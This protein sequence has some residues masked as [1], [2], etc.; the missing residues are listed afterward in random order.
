MPNNEFENDKK[1]NNSDLDK[2]IAQHGN[3]IE[4]KLWRG[5]K[6]S[7]YSSLKV[8]SICTG[9]K[10][11]NEQLHSEGWP[12][13]SSHEFGITQSGIGELRLLLPALKKLQTYSQQ[14]EI[15]FISPPYT[16]FAPALEQYDIDIDCVTVINVQ[17]LNERLWATEQSLLADCCAAV[18]SWYD[19]FK[20]SHH[21]LR[22]LQLATEASCS[23]NVL[24][25]DS[26]RL[27]EAS[28]AGLRAYLSSTSY[29]KLQVDI[30][31]QPNGWAGQR[32]IVSMAP[33]YENWQ[34]IS[35]NLLPV[36]NIPADLQTPL[37]KTPKHKKPLNQ[38][39][40]QEKDELETTQKNTP[41]TVSYP[42]NWQC[43]VKVIA[44]LSMVQD[45][46]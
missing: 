7:Q 6:R 24:F 17:D 31:K 38:K 39:V 42:K 33:H 28:A 8:Q 11:I 44:A 21:E 13:S 34:R 37:K 30:I 16:L 4:G 32:C 3:K 23:W 27:E 46:Y 1:I 26:K 18:V 19:R 40:D 41:H 22:R 45:V 10:Q 14:K 9:Y 5:F 15:I 43:K 2:F 29:C 35:T 20:I 12:L 25:R 36:N